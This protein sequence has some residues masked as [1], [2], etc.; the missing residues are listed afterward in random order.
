M[1]EEGD[2]DEGILTEMTGVKLPA[3]ATDQFQRPG[4]ITLNNAGIEVCECVP[5]YP[6]LE[7][8]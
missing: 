1:S 8:D 5:S 7:R 3:D 6:Y 2:E 4:F